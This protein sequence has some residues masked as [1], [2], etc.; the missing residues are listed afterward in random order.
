[1]LM[2]QTYTAQAIRARTYYHPKVLIARRGAEVC[3]FTGETMPRAHH[4]RSFLMRDG[5]RTIGNHSRLCPALDEDQFAI[6]GQIV[7][8]LT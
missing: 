6:G 8:F 3:A 2:P 5:R 7:E 1:M 4:C